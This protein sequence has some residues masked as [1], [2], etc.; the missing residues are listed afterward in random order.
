MPTIHTAGLLLFGDRQGSA[1]PGGAVL[2]AGRGSGT[3]GPYEEL[4]QAHP[5]ARVRR[6]PGLIAPGLVNPYGPE[7]LEGAYHPDPREAGELGTEPISGAALA[8]LPMTDARWGASARRGVQRM[9]AHGTVAVAGALW[10][11]A[12]LDAVH[13]AGLRAEERLEVPP[14]PPALDPLAG[15]SRLAEAV[16]T[17]LSPHAGVLF[18][19]AVFDAPDEAAL[20]ERGAGCCV[21]T[22]LGGRLVHRR[23]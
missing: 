13:R 8:A 14:G 10:R 2:V 18:G 19:F 1:L 5:D 21:A 16:L 6:W 23:R 4:A 12:V 20:L 9:L 3:V 11:P 7:L 17:P 15:R 22:V